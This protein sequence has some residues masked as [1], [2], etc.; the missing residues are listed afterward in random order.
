MDSS[1]PDVQDDNGTYYVKDKHLYSVDEVTGIIDIYDLT[2]TDADDGKEI[3]SKTRCLASRYSS[4]PK[5]EIQHC[6]WSVNFCEMNKN[7]VILFSNFHGEERRLW[8]QVLSH[9]NSNTPGNPYNSVVSNRSQY[10][11]S[12]ELTGNIFLFYQVAGGGGPYIEFTELTS[13]EY[14]IIRTVRVPEP[15]N[16]VI[17]PLFSNL[18]FLLCGHHG[19]DMMKLALDCEGETIT[20]VHVQF[21]TTSTNSSIACIATDHDRCFL[22][23]FRCITFYRMAI[24]RVAQDVTTYRY[25]AQFPIDDDRFWLD[26]MYVDRRGLIFLSWV[27]ENQYTVFNE[28]YRIRKKPE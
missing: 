10:A 5:P 18:S 28:Y 4:L 17:H 11:A 19:D 14:A 3:V 7:L 9:S 16:H 2:L 27:R 24:A 13:N 8:S 21:P 23:L 12:S 1:W 26:N 15:W 20:F 6:V 22:V 25:L